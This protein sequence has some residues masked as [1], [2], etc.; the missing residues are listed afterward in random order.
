M[1][2]ATQGRDLGT[3]GLEIRRARRVFLV[4]PKRYTSSHFCDFS[5]ASSLIRETAGSRE[6]FREVDEV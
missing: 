2:D 1:T 6:S 5:G 3:T 4:K